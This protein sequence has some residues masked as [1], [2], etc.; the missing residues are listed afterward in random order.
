MLHISNNRQNM[1]K[2]TII[3][4]LLDNY[5]SFINYINELT[6]EDYLYSYQQKWTAGQQLEHIILSVKP[7]VKVFSLDKLVIEQNFGRTDRQS[8]TYEVLVNNYI[9]KLKAGGKAPERFVPGTTLPNQKQVS[10]ETLANLIKEL[11]TKIETFTEQEL[12][13]LLIPHPLLADLTLREMLYHA[14]YHATHH[15]KLTEEN[16]KHNN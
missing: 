14:I 1:N 5:H 8:L 7:L 13:S 11:C 12:D 15:Q 6:P 3:Q 10:L 16:L 2:Q 9:E 4:S